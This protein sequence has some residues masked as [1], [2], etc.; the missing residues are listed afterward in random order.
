VPEGS[1]PGPVPAS[2][3]ILYSA[4]GDSY[5]AEAV[6]SA[7]SSLRHNRLPHLL[8]ASGDAD[9]VQG[10]SVARFEPS[11]NPYADKIANMRRSPFERTIYLDSDTFVVDEIAHVLQLLDCYDVAVAYAAYRALP[12]P[13]VPS[14]F[15][16]FNTGVI[17]WR[18]SDRVAAFMRSW[19]ETYLAWLREGPFPG[20]RKASESRRAD[21]PAFRRCA[22]Q[23]GVRLFVLAPEYNFRF[24]YP[25]TVRERVRVI[26]GRHDDY[27]A[28]AARINDKERL[29]AW[30]RPLPLR[31]RVMRRL[32]PAARVPPSRPGSR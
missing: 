30:P 13:D 31:A 23:H 7:R 6:R 28:L 4:A 14:A 27:E 9:S 12:D 3:G 16:E 25:T 5:V 26:H 29:R 19:E 10:L 8:F 11:V 24:D 21:Q 18:A 15:Y 2:E 17:A 32:R 1:G 20:A 22:W